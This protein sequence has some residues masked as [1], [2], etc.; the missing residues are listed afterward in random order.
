M[1]LPDRL[2]LLRI[3]GER[4]WDHSPVSNHSMVFPNSR[5]IFASQNIAS[6]RQDP[7]P[8]NFRSSPKSCTPRTR[9]AVCP[10]PVR[11]H[12]C[13]CRIH[14]YSAGS[15]S[16]SGERP[17]F[18]RPHVSPNTFS[19]LA[20]RTIPFLSA[21]DA[22][23]DLNHVCPTGPFGT[24]CRPAACSLSFDPDE[25]TDRSTTADPAGAWSQNDL[26]GKASLPWTSHAD[27]RTGQLVV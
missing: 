3:A 19:A 16:S 25:R 2:A 15:A 18:S 24:G 10:P 23:L 1:R 5:L 22:A 14:V 17:R 7:L 4:D 9:K 26:L 13:S 27:N 11:S 6:L 21:R 8:S 12:P 20:T